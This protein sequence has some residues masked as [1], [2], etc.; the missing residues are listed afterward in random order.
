MTMFHFMKRFLHKHLVELHW[1]T[2]LY[3]AVTYVVL[4]W[5]FL[6]ACNEIEIVSSENFF[7]W[8]I[9]TASTVGY[10]DFS[11]QTPAGKWVVSLFV[12]PFGLSLFAV[13]VGN[14]ATYFAAQWRKGIRGLKSMHVEN[15]ILVIGWNERRTSHLI[16]LLLREQQHHPEPSKVVLCVNCDMENPL[17]DQIG[18]VRVASFSD[19]A[20]MSRTNIDKAKCIILDNERDD[21]TLTTALYSYGRNP[22][23]HTIVYFKDENLVPLLKRHCP[24]IECTPSVAVEMIAKSAADPGSSFLHHQ[25]LDV[26]EGMTQ[27]SVQYPDSESARSTAQFFSAFKQ[28]YDATLIGVAERK[29]ADI[30][31]NPSL[32]YVIQ[33]GSVIYYIADERITSIDWSLCHV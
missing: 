15:H 17:P 32:D 4:T 6:S 14:A 28:H 27:Y 13:L 18:F 3:A 9:V 29:N 8:L 1:Y 25:L 11:P 19:D 23:A 7:Y 24:N 33:P 12:I 2:M 10:G 5:L 22:D 30:Q 20:D 26:D 16:R 21:E 31:L